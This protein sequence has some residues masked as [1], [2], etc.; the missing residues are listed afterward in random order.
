MDQ[1]K[2]PSKSTGE[3]STTGGETASL[4][5]SLRKNEPPNE[6]ESVETL[7][8]EVTQQF[9]KA[10]LLHQTSVPDLLNSASSQHRERPSSQPSKS[11]TQNHNN[12]NNNH[13]MDQHNKN[14]EQVVGRESQ[15]EEVETETKEG[16]GGSSTTP[17]TPRTPK[18]SLLTPRKIRPRFPPNTFYEATQA[19]LKSGFF[20]FLFFLF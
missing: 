10:T 11:E 1:P 4:P 12:H 3:E 20:L 2:A 8:K 14:N 18:G 17:R 7:L 13:N 19:R 9:A 15:K 5:A 6:S 16:E